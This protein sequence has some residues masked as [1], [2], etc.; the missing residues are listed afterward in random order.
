M[1][2]GIRALAVST[3]FAM[4]ASCPQ[5]SAAEAFTSKEFLLMSE[6]SQAGYFQATIGMAALALKYELGVRKLVFWLCSTFVLGATFLW[7]ELSD[8]TLIYFKLKLIGMS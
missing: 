5:V 8:F 4:A 7:L 6:Q 1:F 3:F 2:I